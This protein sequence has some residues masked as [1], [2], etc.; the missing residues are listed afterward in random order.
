MISRHLQLKEITSPANHLLKQGKALHDR[1]GREKSKLFLIEGAKLVAEAIERRVEV[2]DIVVSETF[3]KQGLPNLDQS[4]VRCLNVMPD[5]L[6][7][8]L[9]TTTTPTGI[10]AIARI[11]EST[12]DD[13]LKKPNPVLIICDSI[14][15]PGNLGTM[16]RSAL[17][18]GA[19]GMILTKGCVDCFNP[20]VVRGGM[21]ASFAL[22]IV[23]DAD[24]TEICVELHERGFKTVLLEPTA[25][26]TIF[27]LD[28]NQSLAFVFGN[29]GHGFSRNTLDTVQERLQIPMQNDTESLNVSIS[30]AI[31]L[32]EWSRRRNFA[33]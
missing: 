20:K 32:F 3:V 17:A 13:C 18:F 19:S 33:N 15:D 6:F 11:K 29:E 21:G 1:P 9:S 27:D 26:K 22:P 4:K 10:A 2:V 12:L 5:K 8:E 14:Q 25:K 16:M 28:M 7:A 24:M 30:A 31:L 23:R